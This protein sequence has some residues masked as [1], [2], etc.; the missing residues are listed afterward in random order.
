MKPEE[1][2]WY[3]KLV[4]ERFGHLNLTFE[5]AEKVYLHEKEEMIP[6]EKHFFS[7]WEKWDFDLSSFRKILDKKQLQI[8][9]KGHQEN[10]KR[11]EKSLVENDKPRKII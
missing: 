8:F 2:K 6:S 4:K 11:Y 7:A 1:Y 9:E 5:Q 10:I 3:I